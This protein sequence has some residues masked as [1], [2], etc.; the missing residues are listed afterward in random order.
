MEAESKIYDVWLCFIESVS[1]SL[2]IHTAVPLESEAKLSRCRISCRHRDVEC[3]FCVGIKLYLP[4]RRQ[5]VQRFVGCFCF[6]ITFVDNLLV[7]ES[8][9]VDEDAVVSI[10]L[11]GGSTFANLLTS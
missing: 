9:K 10:Y 7:G 11:E 5:R 8:E 2:V 4:E 6:A 3:V 1:E